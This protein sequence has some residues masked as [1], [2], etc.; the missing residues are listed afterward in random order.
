MVNTQNLN[1]EILIQDVGSLHHFRTEIPNIIFD[2]ELNS[3]E[4]VLYCLFKKIAG[5]GGQCFKS[6]K[7]L[8]E[9]LK[10]GLNRLIDTKRSLA[11]RGLI[12]IRKR[13]NEHNG[14][15]SDLITIVDI[16]SQN[17]EEMLKKKNKQNQSFSDEKGDSQNQRGGLSKPK[18]GTL[19]TKDK[20]EQCKKNT[21]K[22]DNDRATP[23]LTFSK[24]KSKPSLFNATIKM[25]D[26]QKSTF[27]W[28]KNLKINVDENTMSWWARRY[29][30]QRLET[31]YNASIKKK[32][33]GAYMQTLLKKDA[34]LPTEQTR[35]NRDY[36]IYFKELRKW[37]TLKI[38]LK[39]AKIICG[40]QEHEI[41]F[42]MPHDEFVIYLEQKY[43]NLG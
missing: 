15:T 42:N 24:E 14:N 23:S 18:G 9:D 29:S 2:M 12:K 6:N 38:N 8:C 13:R 3:S 7:T 40:N 39:N 19:K 36:C 43:E 35:F 34:V 20:E 27:E 22:K 4:F 21:V 1:D 32:S 5:D 11:Q 28:L 17:M 31:V 16:W 26:E 30:F 41:I 37:N 33:I 10:W 25:S